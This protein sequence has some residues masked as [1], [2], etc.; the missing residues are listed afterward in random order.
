MSDAIEMRLQLQKVAAY[1]D[2][3]SGVRRSGR[4]NVIF[5]AIMLGIAYWQNV[6][7]GWIIIIGILRGGEPVGSV[8]TVVPSAEVFCSMDWCFCYSLRTTCG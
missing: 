4:E 6:W 7:G 8:H 2:L 1:R 3:C 5:A